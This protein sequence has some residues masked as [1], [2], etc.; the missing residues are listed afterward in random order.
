[1]C[2]F[3]FHWLLKIYTA[4]YAS[5]R[6]ANEPLLVSCALLLGVFI[7]MIVAHFFIRVLIEFFDGLTISFPLNFRNVQLRK[8]KPSSI[9][10][11]IVFS[12]DRV[13]PRFS[14]NWLIMSLSSSAI[15]FV[16]AVM[17]KSSAHRTRFTLVFAR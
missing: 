9:C 10:V 16:F 15:S 17:I 7:T 6:V 13:S 4:H 5:F 3:P 1:M 11:I 8:S 12:S 14:R 2:Q